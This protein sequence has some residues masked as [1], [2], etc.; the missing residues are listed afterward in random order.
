MAHTA[1]CMPQ[2]ANILNYV[3]PAGEQTLA[4]AGAATILPFTV[5]K[6]SVLIVSA[7]A[8]PVGLWLC[9]DVMT[10]PGVG[11]AGSKVWFVGLYFLSRIVV[12][13]NILSVAVEN[14]F[15]PQPVSLWLE[16]Q[17]MLRDQAYNLLDG[18]L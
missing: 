1:R 6:D 15:S 16:D 5:A 9:T 10:A 2:V 4:P 8:I 18:T 13:E 17:E 7:A 14:T 12:P 3:L 11:P